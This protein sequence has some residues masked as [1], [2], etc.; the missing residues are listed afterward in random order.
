MGPVRSLRVGIA[1]LVGCLAAAG[2]VAGHVRYVT[3]ADQAG[4]GMAFLAAALTDPVN[5]A[6]LGAGGVGVLAAVAGYLR[7]RPFRRDVEVFRETVTGYA[8]LL[9]WLLR[10]GFGLPLVG[11]GFAGYLFNPVVVPADAGGAVRLFQIALGF[12]LLFGLA[13]RVAALVGLVAYLLTLAAEPLLVYS[14]EWIPGFLAVA[15]VG[16]G[17]PSADDALAEVAAAEGTFYGRVDPVYDAAAWLNRV[18]E[19]YER[20]VPTVVRVGLGVSFAFLGIFEKLLAPEMATSVV[21]Q[22]RLAEIAPIS[23]ELWVLGAGFAELGLG[24]AIALGAF[25]RM[26]SLSALGVF[27]LTLFGLPD[28]PVLAHIG[29]F[30]LASALLITGA[31][32]Y[33]LDNRI[34]ATKPSGTADERAA[35]GDD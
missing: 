8:D 18:V 31:G 25:T 26:A 21:A 34:G 12:A 11:A 4:D 22:Y 17:R 13:T 30:S 6:V 9:P 28:D 16:S 24:I 2:V 20:L 27:T 29:A 3:D 19:P 1:T 7:V 15:L 10:L 23:P 32:P 14:L 33:A 35:A 5:A